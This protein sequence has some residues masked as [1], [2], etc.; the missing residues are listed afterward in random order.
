MTA[1]SN[2]E[3][4]DLLME[5]RGKHTEEK[6]KKKGPHKLEIQGSLGNQGAGIN[7]SK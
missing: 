3:V 4:S 2:N 6:P 1:P 7:F 5:N